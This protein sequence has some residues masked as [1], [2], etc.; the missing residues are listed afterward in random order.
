MWI[1]GSSNNQSQGALPPVIRVSASRNSK[2]RQTETVILSEERNTSAI[3]DLANLFQQCDYLINLSW[4][5]RVADKETQ[6]GGLFFNSWVNNW[7]YV[8][9]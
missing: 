4:G 3:F 1:I 5:V 8:N 9:A 2:A 7:L 6:T